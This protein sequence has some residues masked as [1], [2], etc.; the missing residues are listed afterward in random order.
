M[1]KILAKIPSFLTGL[2]IRNIS[3]QEYSD[4]MRTFNFVHYNGSL[5]VY[6]HW[7]YRPLN[8]FTPSSWAILVIE[9]MR[10]LK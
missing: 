8:G 1:M 3:G 2:G 6:L 7:L 5:W 10:I 4:T 9:N